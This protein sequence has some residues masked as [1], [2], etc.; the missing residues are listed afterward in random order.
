MTSSFP[1]LFSVCADELITLIIN[2]FI[3]GM[4]RAFRWRCINNV[5]NG[6]ENSSSI[7]EADRT[8]TE[9]E[10]PVG[11][12]QMCRPALDPVPHPPSEPTLVSLTHNPDNEWNGDNFVRNAGVKKR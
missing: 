11:L 8:D 3:T 10:V 6:G 12:S 4:E 9:R 1:V 5:P 2:R 7:G